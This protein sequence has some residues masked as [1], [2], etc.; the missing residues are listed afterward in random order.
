MLTES[1][2]W[3][4]IAGRASWETAE[5]LSHFREELNL[6]LDAIGL[7][8]WIRMA[9]VHLTDGVNMFDA[10]RVEH[11]RKT[12]EDAAEPHQVISVSMGQV[13]EGTAQA[14][15]SRLRHLERGR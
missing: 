11:L 15:R 5:N 1:W 12:Y 10:D 9:E 8:Y 2:E 13:R 14:I 7:G 6:V 4:E 3:D